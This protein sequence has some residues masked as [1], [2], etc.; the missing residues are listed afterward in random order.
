[1]WERR[2]VVLAKVDTGRAT[3][4]VVGAVQRVGAMI[5]LLL[6]VAVV[7]V[8]AAGPELGSAD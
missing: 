3:G 2:V 8:A 6:L 5:T 4:V 7:A 1:M